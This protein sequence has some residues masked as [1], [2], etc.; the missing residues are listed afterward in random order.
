MTMVD[1][2]TAETT[3]AQFYLEPFE[4]SCRMHLELHLQITGI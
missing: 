3:G 4:V 2:L 1:L